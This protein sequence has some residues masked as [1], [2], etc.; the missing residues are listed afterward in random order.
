V[1]RRAADLLA[2]LDD[3]PLGGALADAGHGLQ[4]RDGLVELGFSL[5]EADELLRDAPDDTPEALIAGAL[6]SAR[7]S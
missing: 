5:V 2:Q 7:K 1:Q 3:D 6:R 4:A